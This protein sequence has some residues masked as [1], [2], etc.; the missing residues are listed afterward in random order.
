MTLFWIV[1]ALLLAGALLFVLPPLFSRTGRPAAATTVESNLSVYRDQLR[2]LEAEKTAG[3]LSDAQYRSAL[4]ELEGRVIEDAAEQQTEAAPSAGHSRWLAGTLAATIPAVA[5]TLY[6]MLGSPISID[7]PKMDPAMAEGQPHAIT[8]EMIMAMVQRLEQKLQEN[9]EDPEG[10]AML[11]RSYTA[12]GRYPEASLAYASATALQPQNAQLLA[13]YAD[14]L[15]MANDRNLLGEPEAIIQKALAAD[16]NNL[17]ALA[18]AGTVAFEKKNYALAI[19]QWQ[20]ILALVPPDSQAA[21]SVTASLDEARKLSGQP[22]VQAT[23][24]QAPAPQA[25]ASGGK[26]SGTVQLDPALK[27]RVAG[28]DTLFVFARFAD[29]RRGPPLAITRK[30]AGELPLQ[31]TLDDSMAMMPA[32]NLTAAGEVLVGARVSKS[33]NASPQPGDLEG[34]SAP[35]KVGA[36]GVSITISKVVQ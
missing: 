10:W 33:G 9:P 31:F 11:A 8:P 3:T 14:A 24:Q 16:P 2:E 19:E 26:V 18:L 5:I 17:K 12:M 30:T 13:D 4:S 1:A 23:A 22:A 34:Y 25:A 21:Q 20:K 27:A 32:F 28:G 15:A 36:T 7:P 35:T 6:L 29:G